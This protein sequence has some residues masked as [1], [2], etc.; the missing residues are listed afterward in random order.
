[1]DD[2]SVIFEMFLKNGNKLKDYYVPGAHIS[3]NP[4]GMCYMGVVKP[5]NPLSYIPASIL[6]AEDD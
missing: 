5:K 4:R 1:M 3:S 6:H 2:E